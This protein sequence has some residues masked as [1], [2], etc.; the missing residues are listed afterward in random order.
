MEGGEWRVESGKWRV[1]SGEWRVGGGG[2]V[3]GV[4]G[5]SESGHTIN[6]TARRFYKV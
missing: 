6:R 1:E 2:G 3:Q 5:W 4:F